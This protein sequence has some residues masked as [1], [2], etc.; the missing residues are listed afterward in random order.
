PNAL[1]NVVQKKEML[2]NLSK[3]DVAAIGAFYPDFIQKYGTAGVGKKRLYALSGSKRATEIV[4]I[5]K[6]VE[7]FKGRLQKNLNEHSWQEFLRDNILLFNS[8][9]ATVLEK[10]N[11]AVLG[12]KFPDFLLIDAYSYLDFYEIK[13]PTTTLLKRDESRGNYYWSVELSK[14]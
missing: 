11:V 6:V 14:A 10:A 2:D 3:D 1:A 9:Y 13:K 12:T 4:Y 7:D 8:N 5:K